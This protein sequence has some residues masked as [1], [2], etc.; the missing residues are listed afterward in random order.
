VLIGQGKELAHS[1]GLDLV[2]G[3]NEAGHHTV[4]EFVRLEIQRRL[5]EPRVAPLQH[6]CAHEAQSLGGPFQQL[7]D[8]RFAPV[9][10]QGARQR[11]MEA[12]VGP[13]FMKGNPRPRV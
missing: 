2:Q 1:L 4:K 13:S 3:R 5:R 7:P 11:W 9:P 10:F 8:E 6:G 12:V